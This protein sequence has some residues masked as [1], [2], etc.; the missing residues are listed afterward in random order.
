VLESVMVVEDGCRA[1][2]PSWA[3]IFSGLLGLVRIM[4]LRVG[5]VD[6]LEV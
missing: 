5:T 3:L 1:V 4:G 2:G 6:L